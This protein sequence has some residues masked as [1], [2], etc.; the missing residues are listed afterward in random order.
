MLTK[1]LLRFNSRQGR[2]FPRFLDVHNK[3]L[4]NLAE[5]LTGL[6]DSGRGQSREELAE[7]AAPIINGHRSTLIAKGLNK[8]LL[9]RCDFQE[10]DG[11]LEAFRQRVFE[12][13]A[14]RMREPELN[15]LRT[16]RQAVGENLGM[17]PDPLAERL[18]ADLPI[19]Q[20]LLAFRPMSGEKLLHRYNLAQAQGPLIW[21]DALTLRFK[22]PA[23]GKR[24]Q[25]F[26]YLK[27]FRLLATVRQEGPGAFF[28]KLDGPLSLFDNARKYGL[29]LAMILPAI[30]LLGQWRIE[31]TVRIGNHPAARLELDETSGLK[32]HFSRTSAYV[33]DSFERFAEDFKKGV[34]AWNIQGSIP[35]LDLGGQELV[36]PDFTFRHQSGQLVHLE[37]FHR[38]HAGVLERRLPRLDDDKGNKQPLAIGVDRALTRETRMAR[39]LEGSA[40]YQRHG[41]PFNEFPPLKRV[42]DCL[43][44]FLSEPSPAAKTTVRK[45][46]RSSRS[47]Q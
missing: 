5:E 35:L 33:P 45:K 25:F 26:R 46:K 11:E 12:T 42:V 16:F 19:R 29:Q 43:E 39:L 37:L 38:W 1:D 9:D 3:L 23:I 44:G 22:E 47:P 2:I 27:F 4:L 41:F 36:V 32:S 15:N 13:A 24:R 20:P 28:I 34:E 17:E 14:Q 7:L 18:H 21:S 40:W 6:Y 8:L 31:A 30:C 10:P